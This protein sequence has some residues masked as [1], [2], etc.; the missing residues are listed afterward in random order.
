MV[1]QGNVF[2]VDFHHKKTILGYVGSLTGSN[3]CIVLAAPKYL[4][5]LSRKGAVA[6]QVLAIACVDRVP[7]L[8]LSKLV[9]FSL[10]SYFLLSSTN[11]KVK[12]ASLPQGM[13]S[14]TYIHKSDFLSGHR[15]FCLLT[16]ISVLLSLKRANLFLPILLR[17]T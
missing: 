9:S 12:R 16:C 11:C 5:Q 14:S 7:A 6:L 1:H 2:S 17:L 3:T 4:R 10:K 13:F 15:H 8:S